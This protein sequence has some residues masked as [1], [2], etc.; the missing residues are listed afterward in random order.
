[1]A[2]LAYFADLPNGE[3]IAFKAKRVPTF[4][5]RMG[6]QHTRVVEPRVGLYVPAGA[7]AGTGNKLCGYV[8]GMGM[9]EITRKVEMKSNPSRHECDARC[10]NASGRTMNCECS[11]GGANH[12]KGRF[13]CE[14]A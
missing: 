4:V 10:M 2:S 9:V 8:E 11:C 13:M 6:I 5:D 1:M 12:G 14:A 7:P 3:T